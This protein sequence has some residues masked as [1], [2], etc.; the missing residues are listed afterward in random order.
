MATNLHGRCGNLNSPRQPAYSRP[1][2][3][4]SHARPPGNEEAVGEGLETRRVDA[5]ART[6]F[7]KLDGRN[8]CFVAVNIF[9]KVERKSD[10]IHSA[11]SKE[12]AVLRDRNHTCEK[13]SK[14]RDIEHE[15][16][17]V[18]SYINC[19]ANARHYGG[20]T[21]ALYN[22]VGNRKMEVREN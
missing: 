9:G 2:S 6:T 12:N 8:H 13:G 17:T 11:E 22:H 3:Q 19:E 4:A 7:S 14:R 1:S 10:E 21:E 20:T 15:I 16:A 5:F 18:A